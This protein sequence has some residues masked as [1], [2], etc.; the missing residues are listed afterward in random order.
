[1]QTA[2]GTGYEDAPTGELCNPF[3]HPLNVTSVI[4]KDVAVSSVQ[5]ERMGHP[6]LTTSSL[7][8]NRRDGAEIIRDLVPL[9]FADVRPVVERDGAPSAVENLPSLSW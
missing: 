4:V 1:L 7:L 9:Y 8:L 6:A 5:L 3:D 2:D